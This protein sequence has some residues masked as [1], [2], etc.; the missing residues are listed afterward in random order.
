M[1]R[2]WKVGTL[3]PLLLGPIDETLFAAGFGVESVNRVQSHTATSNRYPPFYLV[4]ILE[5]NAS[6]ASDASNAL[7]PKLAL[8]YSNDACNTFD[9]F[10]KNKLR[11]K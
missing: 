7:L 3:L 11:F 1:R 6:G 4:P 5:Q 10:F 2:G 8:S 9:D